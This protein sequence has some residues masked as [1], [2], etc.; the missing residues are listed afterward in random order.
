MGYSATVWWMPTTGEFGP[1]GGFGD[2]EEHQQ[3]ATRFG[4]SAAHAR[5]NRAAALSSPTPNETQV[6]LSD[7]VYA[8]EQGA[9]ADSVTVN[10]LDYDALSFDAG[11]KYKGFSFQGEFLMRRLSQFEAFDVH[12]GPNYGLPVA[13]ADNSLLD[14]S[15]YG[16]AG[17]MVVEKKLMLYAFGSYLFDEFERNPWEVGGGTSF[18]PYGNRSLRLNLHVLHIDKS[19]AGSNFGYYTSGQTGT[20]FSLGVDILL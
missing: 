3:L 12:Q 7:G 6:R 19:P 18:Y 14:K 11:F 13:L 20:T 9:L 2:L 15:L 10:Y 8:F 16:S 4:L 1:R 5:E 17:Q